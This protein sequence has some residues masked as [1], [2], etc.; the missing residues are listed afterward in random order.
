MNRG[1]ERVQLHAAPLDLCHSCTPCSKR[2]P[3]ALLAALCRS[4]AATDCSPS[5]LSTASQLP[6]RPSRRR[7][8]AMLEL[9]LT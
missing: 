3:A 8:A 4:S 7:A 6:L 9:E 1:P 5:S 2:S